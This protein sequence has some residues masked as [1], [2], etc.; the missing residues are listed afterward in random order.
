M[1]VFSIPGSSAPCPPQGESALPK[2]LLAYEKDWGWARDL[3]KPSGWCKL[4]QNLQSFE[5][6]GDV[7]STFCALHEYKMVVNYTIGG[8]H[9]AAEPSTLSNMKE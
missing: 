8:K 3:R 6:E 9:R 7:Q 5:R 4:M 1:I 2:Q